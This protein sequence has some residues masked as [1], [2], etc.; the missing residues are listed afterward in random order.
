MS[1]KDNLSMQA[2][3]AFLGKLGLAATCTGAAVG[4]GVLG[5]VQAATGKSG[6][7]GNRPPGWR[8]RGQRKSRLYGC[9]RL[10]SDAGL[11]LDQA[12]MGVWR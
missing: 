1:E 11:R 10:V 2:R 12:P 9:R 6:D 7:F 4:A 5:A 3:R 8:P